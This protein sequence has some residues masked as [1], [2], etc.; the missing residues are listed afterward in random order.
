MDSVFSQISRHGVRLAFPALILACLGSGVSP[1]FCAAESAA[2]PSA[3]TSPRPAV[4]PDMQRIYVFDSMDKSL[5]P[6]L[7]RPEDPSVP[8]SPEG[9]LGI[10]KSSTASPAAAAASQ[11]AATA[12]VVPA[13]PHSSPAPAQSAASAA[14]PA[15]APPA[16]A[17]PAYSPTPAVPAGG[18]APA[19]LSPD[20]LQQ[21]IQSIWKYYVRRDQA[22][23]PQG[24][25]P[26]WGPS[27]DPAARKKV[28]DFSRTY[29]RT[30][31][32]VAVR[33]SASTS[34]P[35]VVSSAPRAATSP[36]NATPAAQNPTAAASGGAGTAQ[37]AAQTP[38]AS[39]QANAPAAQAPTPAAQTGS[40]RVP[41]SLPAPVSTAA[42]VLPPPSVPASRSLGM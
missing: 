31:S 26:L 16:S 24:E 35:A 15:A 6:M 39:A 28:T 21:K 41:S 20:A 17:Y 29:L 23:L 1:A 8:V 5:T 10:L 42:P 40:A 18:F 14:R 7:C 37:A 32:S 36:Q 19:S 9:R 34:A 11:P 4:P 38:A 22:Y 30:S 33:S 13:S 3:Q 12:A 2:R 27:P 25:G